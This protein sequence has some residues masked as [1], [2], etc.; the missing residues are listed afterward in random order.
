MCLLGTLKKKKLLIKLW[1][2]GE[3]RVMWKFS[4]ITGT[5][6]ISDQTS[7]KNVRRTCDFYIFEVIC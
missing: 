2:L 7:L 3:G 4:V 1:G 5:T 6:C